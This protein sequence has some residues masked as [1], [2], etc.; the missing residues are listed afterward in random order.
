[1][2]SPVVEDD[3]RIAACVKQGLEQSGYGMAIAGGRKTLRS[4][5]T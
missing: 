3:A 5:V 1:M 2:H 4:R